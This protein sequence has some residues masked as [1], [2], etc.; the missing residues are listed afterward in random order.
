MFV[1][2]TRQ[3]TT[4]FKDCTKWFGFL[5]NVKSNL[6]KIVLHSPKNKTCLLSSYKI[7][8]VVDILGLSVERQRMVNSESDNSSLVD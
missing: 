5:L 8:F 6:V 4:S 2:K 1:M 7:T 3:V